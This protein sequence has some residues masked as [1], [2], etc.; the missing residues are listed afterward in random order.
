MDRQRVDTA[1]E[2]V[3]QRGVDHAVTLDPALPPEGLRYDIDPVMG[4]SARPVAGVAF[5]VMGLI[6]HAQACRGES[7]RQ[8]LCD[9]LSGSH[10]FGVP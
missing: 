8:L 6:D 7:L 1:R 2:L 9:D 10:G 3:R 4:L 5:V